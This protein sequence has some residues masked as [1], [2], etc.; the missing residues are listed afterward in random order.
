[1][2]IALVQRCI[3][4]AVALFAT[5]VVAF[6]LIDLLPGDPAL[7]M[8]GTE[9][10][11]DTL[12]AARQA[13][14]LDRPPVERFFDWISGVPFGDFGI[15]YRYQIPV[16]Q[17]I[18]EGAAVT[19]P[20]GLFAIVLTIAIALPLGIIAAANQGKSAD[21]GVIAFSQIGLAVPNFW[22]AVL[23][24]LVFA[25]NLRWF[26]AGGFP[27]WDAGLW[28]ALKALTLPAIAL[29]VPQ[30]AIIA[31][32][33]RS[34][35]LDVMGADYIRTARA[36]GLGRSAALWRHGLRNA[37]I[38]IITVMGLQFSVLLAG[39]VIIEN[40]FYLPGLGRMIF[41]AIS[42]NDA[43]VVRNL[44]LLLAGMIMVVNFLVDV[45]YVIVNPRLRAA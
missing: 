17:M 14:G 43:V 6:V 26:D 40:V 13:L 20:L 34:A 7:N 8:L 18:A 3:G 31:R 36:K 4:L 45:T 12:A 5:A 1:M 37:M 19:L 24:V 2:L 9:A 38:P 15:S 25:V 33:T 42:Q 32:V 29:A 11:E 16:S 41:L 21:T 23:L 39:S 30:A 28:P 27:G 10:Q 22:F 35:V 44:V